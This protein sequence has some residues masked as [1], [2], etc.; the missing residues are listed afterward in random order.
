MTLYPARPPARTYG[1]DVGDG[2]RLSVAEFGP[3]QATPALFLHGGPGSGWDPGQARLFHPTRWRLVMPDQRGAGDSTPHG[4]LHGNDTAALVADL[5]RLREHLGIARWL[6]HGGS[7]GATLAIEYAK[8]HG[9]RVQAL[10]LRGV[11]LA[12]PE[13]LA[14]FAAPDGIART[15]PGAYAE[16]RSALGLSSGA[17]LADLLDVLHARLADPDRAVAFAAARAW[18]TWEANVMGIAPRPAPSDTEEG[19]ADRDRRIARNRIHVHYCRAGF[20]LGRR[21]CLDG[22]EAVDGLPITLIHGEADRICPREGAV[23]LA[24]LLP[25]TKLRLVPGA[26]HLAQDPALAQALREALDAALP[27][28]P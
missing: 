26:G 21:G 18:A 10:V 9:E 22:I 4:A 13:D 17:G 6:V 23:L 12:R 28:E 3:A 24:R 1:L 19:R 15:L 20:F 5:E 8:R 11:F 2:H 27:A 7:W 14:W 16:L 25:Q